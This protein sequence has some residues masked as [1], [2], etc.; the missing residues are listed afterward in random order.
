M[1]AVLET[2]QQ[3]DEPPIV[4]VSY[5]HRDEQWKDILLP[6]LSQLGRLG[7]LQVWDDRQIKA[8]VDWYA[9]IKE[10]LGKTRCA[11]C[12]ITANFLNSSFCMDEEIPY[13]LQQRYKGNLEIFPVLL[14]DCVWE[15]HHG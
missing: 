12:L 4:L 13:L 14:E 9:R 8:G 5:S 6:Q 3:P 11:V 2:I 15:E 1:A 10:I 7:I